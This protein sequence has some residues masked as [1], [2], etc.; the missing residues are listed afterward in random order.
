MQQKNVII[1]AKQYIDLQSPVPFVPI[2]IGKKKTNHDL[3]ETFGYG[4][5][6]EEMKESLPLEY[7][8]DEQVVAQ[9]YAFFD[10]NKDATNFQ[11]LRQAII[12]EEAMDI[13]GD[14]QS[15][16]LMMT[17]SNEDNLPTSKLENL[18]F[19]R[20]PPSSMKI[21]PEKMV[22]DHE[23]QEDV[24]IEIPDIKVDAAKEK[25]EMIYLAQELNMSLPSLSEI[26]VP[27][28]SGGF[29]VTPPESKA[30]VL[31]ISFHLE[32]EVLEDFNL[33]QSA[34]E[35]INEASSID[36]K[37]EDHLDIDFHPNQ[38]SDRESQIHALTIE[39]I[40]LSVPQ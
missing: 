9:Q 30:K 18:V 12:E 32:E 17:D 35:I 36:M 16:H 38:Y 22:K 2:Q 21:S 34:Q 23:N 39:S 31:S 37:E 14:Q 40:G 10:Q 26:E 25:H 5:D 4:D 28:D 24:V 1:R 3:D 33:G 27:M 8:E 7:A 15:P 19:K 20:P 13:Q 6:D 11:I 29:I